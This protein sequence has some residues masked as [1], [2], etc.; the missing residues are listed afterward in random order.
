MMSGPSVLL[1]QG[2]GL[3]AEGSGLFAWVSGQAAHLA[4]AGTLIQG[5][6]GKRWLRIMRSPLTLLLHDCGPIM[7]SP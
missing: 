7:P 3:T 1:V 5:T 2:R 4:A 6:Q